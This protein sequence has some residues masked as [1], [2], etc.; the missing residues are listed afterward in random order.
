M[1]SVVR[2]VAVNA[3][4]EEAIGTG[5]FFRIH[6][7]KNS[8]VLVTNKHVIEGAERI[9]IPM[10][11]TSIDP[12]GRVEL[13]RYEVVSTNYVDWLHHPEPDVD[14]CC[15]KIAPIADDFKDKGY[16]YQAISSTSIMSADE[17]ERVPT[18][19]GI[20]MVGFPNGLW[21]SRHGLP[22]IRHG[23]TASHAAVPFEGR[24]DVVVDVA[25]FPGS[26]GSPIMFDDR[27]Y[28]ASASRFLGVLHSGPTFTST[29]DV[30]VTSIPTKKQVAVVNTMMHLGYAVS[31]HRVLELAEIA[32][33]EG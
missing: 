6:T 1:F 31:A 10:H 5:F 19:I 7:A 17:L 16:Y 13:G 8:D 2:L 24:S 32:K 27:H 30:V 22:I 25:C 12:D 3:E 20:S 14:L 11:I 28:F 4:G 21:D 18:S 15:L 23:V 26:S 29:G 33:S 9:L